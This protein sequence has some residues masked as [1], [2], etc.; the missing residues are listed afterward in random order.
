MRPWVRYLEPFRK[1]CDRYLMTIKS[2]DKP[3]NNQYVIT[4][5]YRT[6]QVLLSFAVPPHRYSLA[7]I[8]ERMGLEKNQ[9]Y[10]SLKTLEAAG[11]IQMLEDER[12]S[13]TSLLHNLSSAGAVSA[14]PDLAVLAR[15]Y[16]DALVQESGESVNVFVRM[17]NVA[18][19]IDRR[20]SPQQVRLASVL[21]LSMPL[22]A[23]AVPKAMLAHLP[24]SEQQAV[25]DSLPTLPRYTDKTVL[26][27]DAL[28]HELA[29]IKQ[30]GYSVSDEDYDASARGVGAAIFD[31]SGRVVGGISVG[32]PSFRV[33]DATLQRFA[34]LITRVARDLSGQLGY[35]AI[36]VM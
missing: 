33:D 26:D 18:V 10:R 2:L 3:I 32:G 20:D 9:A 7:D 4:S 8:V 24:A 6:L 31:A 17:G 23:G 14:Q 29:R 27:A 11:F 28:K 19:C 21:G 15:P 1:C 22:H 34:Q 13:L 30:Q 5:A 12:F 25:L 36:N 35:T 16:I